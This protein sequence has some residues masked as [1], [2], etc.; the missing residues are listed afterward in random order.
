[1]KRS[2]GYFGFEVNQIIDIAFSNYK[3]NQE[4]RDR[5]GI[6]GNSVIQDKSVTIIDV[7]SL[8]PEEINN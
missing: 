3:L 4:I 7:N 8:M 5:V 1:M 6:L 2:E